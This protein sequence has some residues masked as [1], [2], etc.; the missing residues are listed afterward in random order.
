MPEVSATGID[1]YG[2]MSRARKD[3][4]PNKP[5]HRASHENNENQGKSFKVKPKRVRIGLIGWNQVIGAAT[6]Q[7]LF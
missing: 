3:D 5:G 2:S 4:A 7:L 1:G 6:L